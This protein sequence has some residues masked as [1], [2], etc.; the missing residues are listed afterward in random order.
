M[1]R[2]GPIPH[3]RHLRWGCYCVLMLCLSTESMAETRHFTVVVQDIDYYP[4]YRADPGKHTYSGYM[5]DLVAAFADHADIEFSYRVRPIRRMT[6]EYTAGKYDFAVPDNPNWNTHEKQGLSVNYTRPLLT[7]EDAI[8]VAAENDQLTP[9]DMRDIGTIAGFTPWKF[10]DRIE[11][12]QVELKTT[13][14]PA[15]LIRM[16]LAGHVETVNLAAPVARH[17]FEALDVGDRLVPAPK[18]MENTVS[19]YHL[20]TIKHPEVIAEFNRFL[21]EQEALVQSLQQQ[22]GLEK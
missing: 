18:L 3:N 14:K 17:Q 16:A 5:A 7:F 11:S 20:S 13:R 8:Y 19:H 4:I 6:L 12:G 9:D 2:V 15:N 10:K 21:E 22:Y 1:M